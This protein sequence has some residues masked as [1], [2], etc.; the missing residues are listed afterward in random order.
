MTRVAPAVSMCTVSTRDD[1]RRMPAL[2][3]WPFLLGMTGGLSGMLPLSAG[4]DGVAVLVEIEP[5][6]EK[7]CW[8]I[9]LQGEIYELPGSWVVPWCSGLA[10]FHGV[11]PDD[12]G[13][14]LA[15]PGRQLKTQ[16]LMACD[17]RK[18]L[19]SLGLR[20]P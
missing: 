11:D 15:N 1:E 6:M 16:A 4:V 19:R 20:T 8:E 9:E 3:A 17:Q 7:E 2:A 14:R 12:L 13:L 18:W 10:I 5:G